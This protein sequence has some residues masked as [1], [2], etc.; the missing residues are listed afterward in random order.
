MNGEN[1]KKSRRKRFN[2]TL[3]PEV[4]KIAAKRACV[5]NK[6]TSRYIEDLILQAAKDTPLRAETATPK[7]KKCEKFIS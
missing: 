6:S 5:L 2:L 4:K 3:I 7:S 1:K